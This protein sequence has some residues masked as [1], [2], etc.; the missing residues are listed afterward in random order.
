ML[1]TRGEKW[2]EKG[3]YQEYLTAAAFDGA[4]AHFLNRMALPPTWPHPLEINSEGIVFL[5][6]VPQGEEVD[7]VLESYQI[8]NEGI[9]ERIASD[10]QSLPAQYIVDTGSLLV[11]VSQGNQFRFYTPDASLPLLGEGR[12]TSCVWANP[13]YGVGDPARGFWLPLGIYG[14]MPIPVPLP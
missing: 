13:E 5:G 7:P 1:Y 8:S 4:G 6:Y 3:N 14:V 11:V 12:M 2:D 10:S 9:F